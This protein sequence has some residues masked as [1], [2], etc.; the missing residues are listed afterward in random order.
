LLVGL[1]LNVANLATPDSLSP[2]IALIP[3]DLSRG[4]LCSQTASR[5]GFVSDDLGSSVVKED[6]RAHPCNPWS[7]SFHNP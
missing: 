1:N 2:L 5:D 6:I 3:T 7:P 4:Q